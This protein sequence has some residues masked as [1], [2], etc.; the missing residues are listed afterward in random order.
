M[1]TPLT[2]LLRAN[3]PLYLKRILRDNKDFLV[4]R[5]RERNK[6]RENKGRVAPYLRPEQHSSLTLKG[7][8]NLGITGVS[9]TFT[10]TVR[11]G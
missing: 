3:Q 5:L 8:S 7:M 11:G 1:T 6:K 4:L 10:M 9:T 2:L